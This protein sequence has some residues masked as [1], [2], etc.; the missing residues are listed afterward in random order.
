MIEDGL[1]AT[2]TTM[3]DKDIAELVVEA[4]GETGS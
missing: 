4:I 3:E 1:A 2:E